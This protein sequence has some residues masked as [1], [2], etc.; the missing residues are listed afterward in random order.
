MPILSDSLPVYL[1]EYEVGTIDLEVPVQRRNISD[2]VFKHTGE[3]AFQLDSVLFSLFY[4]SVSEARTSK[5]HH[6]WVSDVHQQGEGYA[7]FAGINNAITNHIFSFALWS[8]VG[9]TTIPANVD[10]PLHGTF[11][12]Q[13][14]FEAQEPIDSYGHSRFP[15]IVFSHG[16]ASSRTSY[17]QWCGELAS[18]GFVVA[19]IEHRDGSGPGSVVSQNDGTSRNVFHI[20]AS[21]LDPQ[22][23]TADFKTM[24]LAMRQAEVEE[25]VNALRQINDGFGKELFQTNPRDEGMDLMEWKGRLNLNRVVVAGHSYGATLALQAL[26]DAPTERLPFVGGIILDPGK[27]SGPLNNDIKVPIIVVHSQTWSAHCSIFHGRPHFQVVK[28]LVKKVLH[29]GKNRKPQYAWFM[30]SKETS[31]ASVT[32]APLIEPTILSWTTGSTIDAREGVLQYVKVSEEFMRYLEDGRRTGILA[33]DVTHENY[34]EPVKD[35]GNK[36]QKKPDPLVT[37]Y[38]QIHVAPQDT[39]D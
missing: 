13:L 21:Q 30:T 32:D 8:L 9:S 12:A 29:G 26:K 27:H 3:P 10:V 4:P 5:A 7:R 25:T 22:P 19:A 16:A 38:W 17:T 36:K 23:E 6:S 2:A 35:N 1:G 39:K 33:E 18:R 34:D 11:D 31:H 14:Q 15:V 37:R 24:Q 20:S 28:G